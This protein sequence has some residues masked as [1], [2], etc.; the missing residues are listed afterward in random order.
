MENVTK[1]N[2][3]KQNYM[4]ILSVSTPPKKADESDQTIKHHQLSTNYIRNN[5]VEKPN[6]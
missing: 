6:T 3:S 5:V 1:E 4:S 2:V